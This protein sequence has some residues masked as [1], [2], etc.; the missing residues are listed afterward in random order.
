M[1]WQ[2]FSA[3]AVA[4]DT[5]RANRLRE[6]QASVYAGVSNPFVTEFLLAEIKAINQTKLDGIKDVETKASSQIAIVGSGLGLF[7]LIVPKL[8]SHLV[9]NPFVAIGGAGLLLLSIMANFACVLPRTST[10]LPTLDEYNDTE[11][12]KLPDMK[13][14]IQLEL[15]EAYLNYSNELSAVG[16]TKGNQQRWGTFLFVLGA[17]CLLLNF[18]TAALL[19]APPA[20]AV[21]P[22]KC[23]PAPAR[24]ATTR[25]IKGGV[26]IQPPKVPNHGEK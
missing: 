24:Q 4:T 19:G 21:S 18:F 22:A 25:Q 12:V 6:L 11:T 23:L 2:R 26:D 5:D 20:K 16:M 17:V 9:V 7:S 10:A 15:N 8:E 1:P 13:A 3:L 14:R